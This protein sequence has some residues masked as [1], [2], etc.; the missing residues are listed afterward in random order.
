M[1]AFS[2]ILVPVDFSEP[3]RAA[4]A[5]AVAIA[6]PADTLLT[7]LHVI[8]EVPYAE[9]DQ[10]D[11]FYAMLRRRAE[12]RMRELEGMIRQIGWEGETATE[13]VI[14]RRGPEIVRHAAENEVDLVVMSSHPIVADD[15]SGGWATLSYQV[16]IICPCSVL[17]VKDAN[18]SREE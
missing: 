11:A 6:R 16:S 3:N 17:L 14:G 15:L 10:I 9:D 18:N 2:H 12:Q 8:E 13:I 5:K 1:R 7:L 4:I